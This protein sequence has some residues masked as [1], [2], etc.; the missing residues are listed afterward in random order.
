MTWQKFTWGCTR[1]N[2]NRLIR[3]QRWQAN[4]NRPIC[5]QFRLT[6]R[7]AE[8]LEFILAFRPHSD[9]LAGASTVSA[10]P[11]C[12]VGRFARLTSESAG[13][14][15]G[16]NISNCPGESRWMGSLFRL[17]NAVLKITLYV[18]IRKAFIRGCEDTYARSPLPSYVD[19]VYDMRSAT[20]DAS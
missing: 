13:E 5:S 9:L 8:S 17:C 19:Q 6:N 12:R 1:T 18:Q 2:R 20:S 10:R 11:V 3:R 4:R 15:T 7:P 16:Q 14:Q